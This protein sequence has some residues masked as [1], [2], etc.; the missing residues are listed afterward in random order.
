MPKRFPFLDHQ[1]PMYQQ[2]LDAW[3]REERRLHG[4]DAVLTELLRWKGE[5]D[6]YYASR[7]A[8]AGYLTFPK[9]HASTLTGHLSRET[10]DPDYGKLGKI[11]ARQQI[12]QPTLAEILHYNVDGVGQDG[13]ELRPYFDGVQERA[14]ATGYRWLLVE[15]PGLKDLADLREMQGRDPTTPTITM[16]DIIDGFRPYAVEY[17]PISVPFWQISQ[18][19]LDVA[20]VRIHLTP[21]S[22]VDETGEVVGH[23]Q[24]YYLLVR[25]GFTGAG[26]DWA[27]GGWWKLDPEHEILEQGTWDQTRGQ[28]PLFPFIGEP[29]PGTTERPA[30]GRSLT[31]ELGQISVGLMNRISERNYNVMQSA[32][33]VNWILGI[34]PGEHT[35]TVNQAEAGSFI[36][37]VPPVMLADGTVG[38]PQMWNSSAAA[39]DAGVFESVITS[40]INEAREL[41]VKQVSSTPDSSGRSKEAGFAEATSPLLARLAATRQQAINTFLHFASLRFGVAEPNASVTIPRDFNLQPVIDDIDAMLS[42]LKR[43]WLRSPTWERELLVQAGDERGLLPEDKTLRATILGELDASASPTVPVDELLDDAPEIPGRQTPPPAAQAPLE[44]NGT[45]AA[46]PRTGRASAA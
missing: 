37:G 5:D 45:G 3:K 28:I 9:I 11:R 35:L 27:G 42:T 36:I 16:Q 13:T 40:G 18:G 7:L 12:D 29:D 30:I 19:R 17:S 10:P 2:H 32:K 41:M 44:Q 15:K 23:D 22:L 31:M 4:G 46:Q 6:A 39:L 24:G 34:G 25:K 43:S 21:T 38:I 8:Q 20:V 26:K 33:S 1:L 14:I